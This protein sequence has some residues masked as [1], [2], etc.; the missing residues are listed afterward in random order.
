M[1]RDCFHLNSSY[2]IMLRLQSNRSQAYYYLYIL[3]LLLSRYLLLG[4]PFYL[5]LAN[6]IFH[7]RKSNTAGPNS[8]TGNSEKAHCTD[9]KTRLVLIGSDL[10]TQLSS[11]FFDFQQSTIQYMNH[12][13]RWNFGVRNFQAQNTARECSFL[14]FKTQ[15]LLQPR[16]L[17]F[18]TVVS[19]SDNTGLFTPTLNLCSRGVHGGF[20][21]LL[22][23][24]LH[25]R[26]TGAYEFC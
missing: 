17:R 6:N 12:A 13:L 7:C 1:S 10:I 2:T 18:Y 24:S 23:G 16:T 25:R 14:Y 21:P 11:N 9:S 15:E 4:H 5:F 20:L 19:T 8:E 3:S 26:M 22:I